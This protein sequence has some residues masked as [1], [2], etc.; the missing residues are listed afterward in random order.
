MYSFS[1]TPFAAAF[2]KYFQKLT[3]IICHSFVSSINIILGSYLSLSFPVARARARFCALYIQAF[4]F[5]AF[6]PIARS[7]YRIHSTIQFCV[8]CQAY[9]PVIACLHSLS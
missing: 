5:V 6:A 8:D 4:V 3:D 9:E 1:H 2:T 7:S